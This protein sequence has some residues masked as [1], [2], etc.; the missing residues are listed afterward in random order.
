MLQRLNVTIVVICAAV[1]AL[2]A[3][4]YS[5]EAYLGFVLWKNQNPSSSLLYDSGYVVATCNTEIAFLRL[6][7]LLCTIF[8]SN[9]WIRLPWLLCLTCSTGL[10]SPSITESQ[11]YGCPGSFFNWLLGSWFC[12]E[13]SKLPLWGFFRPGTMVSNPLDQFPKPVPA[14][15]PLCCCLIRGLLISLLPLKYCLLPI[16]LLYLDLI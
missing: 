2:T 7:G 4:Q 6:C 11:S 5:A 15:R 13:P 16:F 9:H 14:H 10:F 3:H 1:K 8:L 12:S